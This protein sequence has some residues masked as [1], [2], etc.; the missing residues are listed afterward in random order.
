MIIY[1]RDTQSMCMW[2]ENEVQVQ[3]HRSCILGECVRYPPVISLASRY[4]VEPTNRT[5]FE[6]AVNA[7]MKTR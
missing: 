1:S 6:T 4:K 7:R 5:I 3:V 2:V